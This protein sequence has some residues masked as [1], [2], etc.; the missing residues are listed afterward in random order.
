MERITCK[1][2]HGLEPIES[3]GLAFVGGRGSYGVGVAI[4]PVTQKG[5]A[6][7]NQPRQLIG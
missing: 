3:V 6:Q 1:G 2:D 5:R 7:I 4:R